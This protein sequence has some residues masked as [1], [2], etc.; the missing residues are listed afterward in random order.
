M[1]FQNKVALITGSGRGIGAVI[2]RH[3]A[4]LGADVSS[5]ISAIVNPRKESLTISGI[6]AVKPYW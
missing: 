1:E 3:F 4:N 2:A 6:W 5:I